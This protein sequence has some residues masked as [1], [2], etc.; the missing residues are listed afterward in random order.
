MQFHPPQPDAHSPL[1][2]IIAG[3]GTGGHLFP[4]IALAEGFLARN[5]ATQILFVG[6]G[7]RLEKTALRN[8][9]YEHRSIS[10]GGLKGKSWRARATA[11]M[12][13]ILG[14]GESIGI[15]C[16][17]R[18]DLVVGV[19][20][21]VSGPMVLTA[22]ILKV[23]TVLHEQNMIPGLT[24]RMLAKIV[25]RVYVTFPET[26]FG[27]SSQKIK[28]TGN[29]VRLS[30]SGL[31]KTTED[32]NES[33]ASG[34]DRFTVL[35]FGGS[36]GAHAINMAVTESLPY[37]PPKELFFIHQT[38]QTDE[39]IVKNAYTASGFKAEVQAFFTDMANQYQ[40]AA[41]VICRAG[42]TTIAEVTAVGKATIF[43]PYP[44]A[45]DDH[46]TKNAEG[47]AR[48][49][50]AEVIVER[51]LTGRGLADRIL[52]YMNRP[53]KLKGMAS[54]AARYGRPQ[55]AEDII[56]DCYRLMVA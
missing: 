33:T 4:G 22:R 5:A 53:E 9:P 14:L 1:K 52:H 17:F 51:K 56:E 7:N 12:K 21:Y 40:K 44:F 38:G 19:G 27:I 42:A 24:N 41:L 16:Q 50:A 10:A 45:A 28:I 15:I 49:G 48:A 37:L 35:V 18:P 43:I 6:T 32:G 47:L 39:A 11:L 34:E 20:G 26:Q 54:T 8:T 46:Q 31:A 2:V 23:P 13:V 55:A 3:G 29:P 36:Q 30:V 25:K